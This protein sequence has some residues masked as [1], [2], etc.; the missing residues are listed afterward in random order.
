ME[1]RVQGGLFQHADHRVEEAGTR[2]RGAAG[3]LSP[4]TPA[5]QTRPPDGVADG[6]LLAG[7]PLQLAVEPSVRAAQDSR[8]KPGCTGCGAIRG[9]QWLLL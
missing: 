2:E 9:G 6:A 8:G 7:V 3:P 1:G 5:G 4:Q